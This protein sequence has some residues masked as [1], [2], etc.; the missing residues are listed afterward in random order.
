MTFDEFEEQSYP[1]IKLPKDVCKFIYHLGLGEEAGEV[2][3]KAKK[4]WRDK[5]GK[6]NKK[7]KTEIKKEL[8]DVLFYVRNIAKEYG[9]T[10][11]EVAQACLDKLDDRERRGVLHGEGDDR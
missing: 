7:F 3:G 1:R 2:L 5:K 10:M 11:E 4:L 9:I 8:G 6:P